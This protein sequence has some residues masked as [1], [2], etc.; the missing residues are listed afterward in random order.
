[1]NLLITKIIYKKKFWM[2]LMF[3]KTIRFRKIKTKCFR[4]NHKNKRYYTVISAIIKVSKKDM[5][6]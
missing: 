2:K 5:K 6:N 4:R 1:M 3:Y